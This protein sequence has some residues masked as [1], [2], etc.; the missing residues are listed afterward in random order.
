MYRFCR[1]SHRGSDLIGG[2]IGS[3]GRGWDSIMAKVVALVVA[4]EATASDDNGCT[5]RVVIGAKYLLDNPLTWW[6]VAFYYCK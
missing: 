3:D 4:M 6:K 2:N 1:T 5:V